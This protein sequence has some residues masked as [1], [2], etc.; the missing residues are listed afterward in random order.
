MNNATVQLVRN[1]NESTTVFCIWKPITTRTTA[2][3][4]TVTTSSTSPQEASNQAPKTVNKSKEKLTAA[5]QSQNEA[6]EEVFFPT[7][8]VSV[9]NNGKTTDIRAILD[10]GFQSNL[11]KE[12]A[13]HRLGL[14]RENQR[15]S[16]WT[17]SSRSQQQ[18]RIS[19]LDSENEG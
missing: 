17:Q 16:F 18:Q 2:T 15:T 3:A 6:E 4:P 5:A 19:K 10:S 8:I 11:I 12:D 7:A 9:D 1:A 14:S 13:V